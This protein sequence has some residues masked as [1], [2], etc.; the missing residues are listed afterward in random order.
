MDDV[1]SKQGVVAQWD[2]GIQ[3]DGD[4]AVIQLFNVI[5]FELLLPKSYDG[6]RTGGVFLNNV[7]NSVIGDFR[8]IKNG[9][10]G[11]KLLGCS[12]IVVNNVGA[13]G[14][15]AYGFWTDSSRDNRSRDNRFTPITSAGNDKVGTWLSN[16]D[17]SL[18]HNNANSGQDGGIVVGCTLDR[19][20]CPGNETSNDN[21]IIN[22]EVTG[23]KKVG[24][25]VRKHSS[26]NIIT[27]N[28]SNNGGKMTD[29]VDD[30]NKCDHNTWYNNMFVGKPSQ[31]C[32]H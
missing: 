20:N 30:N 15:G 21:R 17:R 26:D 12:N 3:D 10:Y 5:G 9:Q 13:T 24:I 23:N 1:G 28:I 4:D 32:I 6:N 2:I 11:V 7:R 19:K 8:A 27:L 29:L 25:I 14:N 31:T 22:N 18:I 16:S